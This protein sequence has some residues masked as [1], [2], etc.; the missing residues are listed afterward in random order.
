MVAAT[1]LRLLFALVAVAGSFL[2]MYPTTPRGSA[3]DTYFGTRVPDPYRWLERENAPATKQWVAEETNLTERTLSGMRDRARMRALFTRLIGT[4]GDSLP[5]SGGPAFAFAHADG[6]GRLPYVVVQID[7][8]QRVAID[9]SSCWPD[10]STSLADWQLSPDGRYIAYATKRGGLGLV[11]WHVLDVAANRDSNGVIVGVPDWS[12][13]EW[14]KDGSGFYYG[15]YRRERLP[16]SGAPIGTGY[17]VHF[18]RVRADPATDRLVFARPD[19]PS[20]LPYVNLSD[21]GRYEIDEAVDGSGNGTSMAIFDLR[22]RREKVREIDDGRYDYVG[23][24]G[25]RIYFFTHV[26]SQRGRLVLID[27][28]SRRGIQTVISPHRDILESV[29]AVGNIFVANF[30]R[31][32][33]SRLA[34]YRHDGTPAGDIA[35]PGPGSVPRISGDQNR[36]T[37][38]YQFSNPTSPPVTYAFDS[39]ARRT[40][41]VTQQTA[42]FDT[43]GFVTDELFARSTDGV[44]IPVFMAHRRHA[45]MDGSVATLL[46]GYGGFGY[47]YPIEWDP[48]GAAWVARGGTFVIACVR[49]GGEYGEAWHRAGMR[50]N[51]HHAFEDLDT[52]ARFLVQHGYT[53]SKRLALYGYSGGG[54]LVGTT[55]VQHPDDF[56]AVVE[57]AGGMDV[58]RQHTFGSE[59]GWIPEV[60]SPT[61]SVAEFK[62]LYAY[63]PL[64]HIPKG[65][66]YPATMVRTSTGDERVSP[67]HAFKFAATM[68]WAQGGRAP[69]RLYVAKNTGHIGGGTISDQATPLADE[70]TFL[71]DSLR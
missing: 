25:S 15:G 40:H 59:S 65:V 26:A 43:S 16:P 3:S 57:A 23:N 32:D 5:Q 53:S 21:D 1:G 36:P 58:L 56:G 67:A 22:H 33:R 19:K 44:R 28:G 42:P 46:T 38:Y 34:A 48:V 61:A 10:G 39:R 7:G 24:R 63:A 60:G 45:P 11:H 31:D 18:H 13:I 9:P 66:H 27:V 30:L 50:G 17:S 37:G 71:L 6:T 12:P 8:R 54:L 68:Q 29:T 49:G 14:A 55:E 70:E 2:A 69:V 47:P 52:V 64:V 4:K 62:W 41:V 51:K 35:L 20:W